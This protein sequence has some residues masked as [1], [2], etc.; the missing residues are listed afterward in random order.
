MIVFRGIESCENLG[1]VSLTIGSF[2]GLHAGHLSLL[3]VLTR[4]ARES[5]SQSLVVTFSPHP[6]IA[7]GRDEGFSLLTT[8]A[9]RL[10]LFEQAGVD[11]VLLLDFNDDLRAMSGRQFICDLLCTTLEVKSVVMG[12]DHRLG[13]DRCSYEQVLELGVE[14]G[15][16]V[17]QAPEFLVETERISSTRLR[18][19]IEQGD[20]SH[21]ALLL[22]RPYLVMGN[23]DTVG[24]VV[25]DDERKLLPAMGHYL[26]KVN[27]QITQIDVADCIVC[28]M[29]S[30]KVKIEFI[31]KI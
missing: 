22:A 4:S 8:D 24:R 17:M 7:M 3:E 18:A 11:A 26:A 29:P 5:C 1:A 12:Y 15:F 31:E 10:Y 30:S 27:D 16:A 25:L 14:C 9:E 2:D 23:S 20:M 28:A 13:H 21:A 6:R 19:I